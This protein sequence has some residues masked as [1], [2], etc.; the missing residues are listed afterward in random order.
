MAEVERSDHA[1]G[2]VR[3]LL[4]W[5]APFLGGQRRL[6]GWVGVGTVIV[7]ACQAT[8]PWL[9][10]ILLHEGEWNTQLLLVLVGLVVVQLAVSYVTH[11]GAHNVANRSARTLRRKLYERM[12]RSRVLRQ[13]GLRR[14]SVVMRFTADVDRTSDALDATLAEGIPGLARLVIS[15]VLLSTIERK[16]GIAMALAAIAFL[17]L[18][19]R[20]GRRLLN[21]DRRRVLAQSQLGETVD[22][23]ISTSRTIG[24]LHLTTWMV[25]RF[26]HRSEEVEHLSHTQGIIVSRLIIGAHAAGLVGLV[27]VVG[28]ALVLGGQDLAA[29]AAAL[30]YVEGAVRGME[31]LPPWIRDVQLSAVSQ[32]RIDDILTEPD[33]I[34]VPAGAAGPT[35]DAA[36]GIALESVSTTLPSGVT[37]SGASV[38]LPP[39]PIIGVVTPAGSEPDDVL[40]LLSGDINPDTGRVT[41]DGVDVRSPDANR[42]I[43]YVPDES[44]AFSSSV[45]DLLDAVAPGITPERAT[46]L[47]ASVSLEHIVSL[48]GGVKAP[49]GPGGLDLTVNER[50]RLMLAVALAAQPRV[51]LVGSLLGLADIDGALPLIDTLRGGTQESTVI[52]VRSAEIAEAVDLIVF[53]ANGRASTGTHQQLLVAEPEYAALWEQRLSTTDVDLSIVG[54]DPADEHRMLSRLVT[55]HYSPGDLIYREGA[56]SDRIVFIISGHV[57]ITTNSADG[58]PRR[59]AVL[60]PGNHCGDLRLTVGERRAESALAL[61]DCVVRSL[62]RQAI[63]AGLTGLLDRTATE[64]RIIESLLRDGPGTADEVGARLPTI[65]TAAFATSVA[66]LTRDG[67]IKDVNG[68]MSVVLQR[69]AKTG[70]R[71]LLDR[72]GDL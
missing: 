6:L 72:L 35:A 26:D 58:P 67:A 30:L 50:Q 70:A 44:D 53:A 52:S 60:G 25:G 39:G 41:L 33:R 49:L 65:D 38:L 12:L 1:S 5:Y 42:A 56:P 20:I 24:G 8:V 55:E 69:S 7:L 22:E 46:A 59:V 37:L 40:G 36:L 66:L 57:E 14:S 29:V 27:V 43:F 23:S 68:I 10:E 51:L 64:R 9:V 18:R 45:L 28:F 71:D 16:A 54:I 47:A 19:R 2:A 62:S 32:H 21:A 15:L 17:L 4:R 48:P 3:D 11:I 13:Q 61:D 31:A 63:A 34:A